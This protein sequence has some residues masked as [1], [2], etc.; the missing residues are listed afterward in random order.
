[1]T[2]IDELEEKSILASNYYPFKTDPSLIDNLTPDDLF[3]VGEDYFSRWVEHILRSL[4]ATWLGSASV[5][6]NACKQVED[7]K[8]LLRITIN[9]RPLDEKVERE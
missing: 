4:G 7:F 9:D 5:W 6:R 3:K 8:Y 1:L 2:R